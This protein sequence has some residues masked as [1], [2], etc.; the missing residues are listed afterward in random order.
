MAGSMAGGFYA[1]EPIISD[2]EG[3]PFFQDMKT[4]VLFGPEFKA[5][6][7]LEARLKLTL[8]VTIQTGKMGKIIQPETRSKPIGIRLIE[9][10]L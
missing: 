4:Q 10:D 7:A 2:G 8:G 3:I 6:M 5:R 9:I 1:P